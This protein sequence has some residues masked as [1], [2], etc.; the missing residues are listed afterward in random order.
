VFTRG[1][2]ATETLKVLVFVLLFKRVALACVVQI[3]TTE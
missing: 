3:I 2:G 1:T